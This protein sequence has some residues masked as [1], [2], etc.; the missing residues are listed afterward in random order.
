MIGVDSC[1][2][3][4]LYGLGLQPDAFRWCVVE[5]VDDVGLLNSREA[6]YI[7]W[8]GADSKGLNRKG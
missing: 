2:N 6:Y 5:I 1:G 3:E 8:F 4:K 7:K